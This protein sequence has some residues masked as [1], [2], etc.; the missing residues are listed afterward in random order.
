MITLLYLFVGERLRQVCVL[1]IGPVA[2]MVEHPSCKQEVSGSFISG[3]LCTFDY[4]LVV[5]CLVDP[6]AHEPN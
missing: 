4:P 6:L 2:Q 1:C 3:K 5:V